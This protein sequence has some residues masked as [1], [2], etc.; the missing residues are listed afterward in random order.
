M[1]SLEE[2]R[3]DLTTFGEAVK[4]EAEGFALARHVQYAILFDRLFRFP[5]TGGRVR[6]YDGLGGQLLFAYL[7]HE[8]YLHWTDNRLVIEWDRSEASAVSRTSSVSSTTRDRPLE[9]RAVDRGA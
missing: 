3:Y 9:A 7:H 2:L 8:G 1:Y 6:N 5:L 4:L